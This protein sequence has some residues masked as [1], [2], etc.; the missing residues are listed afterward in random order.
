MAEERRVPSLRIELC[1]RLRGIPLGGCTV[2]LVLA[3]AADRRRCGAR[4]RRDRGASGAALRK[5]SQGPLDRRRRSTAHR[6]NVPG[7]C[8]SVRSRKSGEI[9][10]ERQALAT[11]LDALKDEARSFVPVVLGGLIAVAVIAR[12]QRL[13]TGIKMLFKI[14]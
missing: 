1:P 8:L 9:A 7:P 10:A 14:L 5:Q 2:G 11:D 12:Q 4:R 6:E 13:R 3:L